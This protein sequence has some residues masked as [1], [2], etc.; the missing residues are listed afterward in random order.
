MSRNQR[1]LKGSAELEGVALH[2]GTRVRV[3]IGTAPPGSGIIF[4]RGDVDDAPDIPALPDYLSS[5]S[6]QT[7]LHVGPVQVGMVEHFLAAC[8][9]LR[10]DNATVV[11]DGDELPGMDG[12]AASYVDLI[13]EAGISEQKAERKVLRLEEPMVLR[14]GDAVLVALPP[15]DEILRIRYIPEY[16]DGV[17]ASPVRFQLKG[18]AFEE[19]VAGARTF[20]LESE[21]EELRAK[22]LGKG[23]NEENTLVLGGKAPPRMRMEREPTRHKILD[24]LGDL[25]LLGADLQADIVANRSGHNLNQELVRRLRAELEALE[26]ASGTRE[27]GYD[28]LEIMQLLPHRYPFLLIDRVTEVE[29]FRRAVGIKN[30]TI[31]EPFFQGHWPDQ[32]MM[33]GVLQLEAMAQLAGF[34]LQRKLEHTGKL[35]V[36]ASIDKV[37]FRGSVQ[38]GDQLRVEAETLRLDRRRGQVKGTAKVGRRVVAE[39]LLSFAMVDVS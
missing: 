16:P 21:I 11:V 6:R 5:S 15:S 10:V 7:M 38:P 34:L 4:R 31:N 9:G 13:K 32:P 36:L 30:V 35:V 26:L 3:R 22:G 19:E 20:V 17:D 39:A 18:G 29:G 12:S 28:I 37:R 24:L 25:A 2:S 1:T 8:H 33:P 14:E 27:S 23:A